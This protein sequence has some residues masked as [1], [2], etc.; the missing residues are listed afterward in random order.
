MRWVWW[1][2]VTRDNCRRAPSS[3]SA[4]ARARYDLAEADVTLDRDF[5]RNHP[6]AVRL[7]SHFA[8]RRMPEEVNMS[9]LYTVESRSPDRRHGRPPPRCAAP[10]SARSSIA[11]R[12]ARSTATPRQAFVAAVQADIARRQEGRDH[13]RRA[14]PEVHAKA[15]AHQSVGSMGTLHMIDEFLAGRDDGLAELVADMNS[16]EVKTP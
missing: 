8:K 10:T 14:G 4:A 9:R 7:A 13:R 12:A 11:G 1:S 16:G 6:D 15:R 2:P 5:Q 3:P